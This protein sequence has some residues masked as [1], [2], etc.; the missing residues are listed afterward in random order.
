MTTKAEAHPGID[1]GGDGDHERGFPLRTSPTVAVAARITIHP[2]RAAARGT[3]LSNRKKTASKGNLTGSLAGSA[4][5]RSRPGFG[6]RASATFAAF[7]SR[8]SDRTLDPGCRLFEAQLEG[9]LKVVS[10]VRSLAT[11]AAPAAENISESEE[12][13]ENI[14]KVAEGTRIKARKSFST[15]TLMAES[16]ITRPLVDV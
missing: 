5:L 4:A 11:A 10:A 12:I 3:G 13:T 9:V 2:S 16:V 14:G 1:T 7:E 6:P 15:K 8:D